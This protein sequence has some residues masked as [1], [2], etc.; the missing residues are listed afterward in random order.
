MTKKGRDNPNRVFG[1]PLGDVVHRSQKNV[2]E[3]L[4]KVVDH[5]VRNEEGEMHCGGKIAHLTMKSALKTEGVFR[6]PAEKKRLEEL[7]VIV[8]KGTST[9]LL[10]GRSI[11]QFANFTISRRDD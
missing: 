10:I 1:A 11:M 8:D 2:P 4:E 9:M 7:R 3:F 5:L 6:V